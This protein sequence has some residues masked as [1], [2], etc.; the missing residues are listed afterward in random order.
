M[1]LWRVTDLDKIFAKLDEWDQLAH[2]DLILL[3]K[4]NSSVEKIMFGLIH[5]MK[6]LEFHHG[7][8]KVAWVRFFNKYVSHTAL[9]LLNLRSE[10]HNN[11]LDLIESREIWIF[12]FKFVRFDE[13]LL[14]SRTKKSD[15]SSK[16]KSRKQ[17]EKHYLPVE[18][19]LKLVQ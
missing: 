17:K 16:I 18:N 14:S 9:S 5:N 19:S 4:T 10:I 11:K 2:E 15:P 7:N 8:C 3:I 13:I 6:S 12:M 1:K